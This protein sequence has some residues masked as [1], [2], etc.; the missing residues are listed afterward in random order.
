MQ[1]AWNKKQLKK[2][3]ETRKKILNWMM[4]NNLR[5]YEAVGKIVAQYVKDPQ[6]I[7][8]MMEEDSK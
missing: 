7:N 6:V 1:F 5:S 8:K 4:K 3:I 2:E